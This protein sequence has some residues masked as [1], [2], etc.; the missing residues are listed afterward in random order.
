MKTL[1]LGTQ[2]VVLDNGF[3]HVGRCSVQDGFLRIE[4]CKNI[5]RWGTTKGLG[6]LMSGPTSDTVSDDIG[7]ALVPISRI[8][9]FIEVTNGG[10]G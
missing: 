6:Q 4:N 5:R 7:V 3:V 9:F 8:V 1:N 10:W 2:I